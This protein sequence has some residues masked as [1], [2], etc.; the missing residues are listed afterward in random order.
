MPY[1]IALLGVLGAAYFWLSRVRNAAAMTNE[2]ADMAGDV[3]AAARRLG[4]R[5]RSNTHPVDSI[6]DPGLAVGGLG[7][8][9]VLLGGTPTTEQKSA[10]LRGLQTRLSPPLAKAE[11]I[12]VLGHWFVNECNGPGAAIPRLGKRIYQ[13]SGTEHLETSMG[14]VSDC[15]AAGSGEL[16]DR[17]REALHDVKRVFRVA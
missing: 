5:R 4:F 16:T 1:I 3:M 2:L 13:L 15:V 9:F 11:E 14:L 6:D 12:E 17:Q 7:V 8:A 10:L